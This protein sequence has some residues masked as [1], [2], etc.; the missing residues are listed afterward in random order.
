MKKIILFLSL[1]TAFAGYGQDKNQSKIDEKGECPFHKGSPA[2][3][4]NKTWWPNQLDLSILRQ[5]SSLS[6]PMGEDFNYKES[7]NSFR[8]RP[9]NPT[10]KYTLGYRCSELTS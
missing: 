4:T 9:P 5:H 6:N 10:N 2:A 7:F 3:M 1:I 8:P